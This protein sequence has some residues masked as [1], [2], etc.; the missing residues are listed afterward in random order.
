M[1]EELSLRS[2]NKIRRMPG[3]DARCG[4]GLD[5]PAG[6]LRKKEKPDG[7]IAEDLMQAIDRTV[8]LTPTQIAELRGMLAS[9]AAGTT[10]SSSAVNARFAGRAGTPSNRSTVSNRAGCSCQ[11]NGRTQ[12]DAMIEAI[13]VG[14]LR[15]SKLALLIFIRYG[16]SS[17]VAL[18]LAY[19]LIAEI[20]HHR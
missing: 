5:A 10:T 18:T 12:W 20:G 19:E 14:R 9:W 4:I 7:R 1:P 3:A 15:A 2:P 16:L 6:R 17:G 13:G 8:S 11:K